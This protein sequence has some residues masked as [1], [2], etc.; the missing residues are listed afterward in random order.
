MPAPFLPQRERHQAAGLLRDHRVDV[1][2]PLDRP[3]AEQADLRNDLLVLPRPGQRRGVTTARERLG[4]ERMSASSLSEAARLFDADALIPIIQSLGEE[5]QPLGK[6]PR[7]AEV[8]HTLTL[9]DGT[10]LS[11]SARPSK[12]QPLA[13]QM[14]KRQPQQTLPAPR[15]QP[16]RFKIVPD[17][18]G[19]FFCPGIVDDGAAGP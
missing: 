1:V 18:I 10:L 15:R 14:S 6:D 12:R 2:Q 8:K 5:L 4:V 16:T 17:G 19:A 7:L 9:V 11:A 13:A 3:Q